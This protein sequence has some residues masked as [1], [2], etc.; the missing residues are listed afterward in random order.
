M[1]S[2][3]EYLNE[4]AWQKSAS[5]LIFKGS[6][7][8]EPFGS[9]LIPIS[10]RHF[11]DIVKQR[12]TVFHVSGVG[13]ARRFSKMEGKKSSV[14]GFFEM[15]NEYLSRGVQGGGGYV[16]EVDANILFAAE[17]DI[18][19]RPDKSGRRWISVRNLI[20][21]N[22]KTKGIIKDIQ[23][24]MIYIVKKHINKNVKTAYDAEFE[25]DLIKY[26]LDDIKRDKR[27]EYGKLM[28]GIIKDYFDGVYKIYKKYEDGIRKVII[29]HLVNRKKRY[30]WDE[31]LFN[32]YKIKKLHVIINFIERNEYEEMDD[33]SNILPQSVIDELISGDKF[34][35][36]IWFSDELNK[37]GDY[38]SRIGQK[39]IKK[40][41]AGK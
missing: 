2:F 27:S 7:S 11:R 23:A 19:S 1:F 13:S 14:S 25:W 26:A 32:D 37:F 39:E 20:N 41:M 5:K 8:S 18:M 34:E 4:L 31:I 21:T 29:S 22:Y 17:E 38:V 3:K 33:K 9:M 10:D 40:I 24:L 28:R 12:A 15:S 6:Y 30:E 16:F 35:Y 36:K